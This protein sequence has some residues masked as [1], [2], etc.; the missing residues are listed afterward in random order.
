MSVTAVRRSIW[1]LSIWG[2]CLLLASAGAAAH[3]PLTSRGPALWAAVVTAALLLGFWAIYLVGSR[4]VAVERWRGSLFHATTLL[5]V[6][7]LLGP[8]DDLAKTSTAA[9]M[10]QHMLLMVVIAPL[11]VLSRPLPQLR[12]GAGRQLAWL[13]QPGLRL[14]AHPQ[15]AACLHAAAIWFWH[16][17][18]FYMLAVKNVWWHALEH[19]CF[20]ATAGIFWWSILRA[21]RTHTPAA[22]LALLFTVMHT[23]FLGALLTFAR[24]PLYHEARDL[25]DQ[26]LAG[27]IMWVAGAIPFLLAAAWIGYRWFQRLIRA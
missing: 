7:A 12:A 10:I 1:G 11:W 24:A 27:L 16:L 4:R 6:L 15:P 17:P 26:Q 19:F 14:A 20:I 23:G 13:W 5:C 3:N 2:L 21:A 8:L 9:H 25:Q 22:L 18:M